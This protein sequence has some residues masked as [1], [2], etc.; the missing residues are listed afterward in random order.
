[1]AI[2]INFDLFVRNHPFH[3]KIYSLVGQPLKKQAKDGKWSPCAIQV[4]Y[5]LNNSGAPLPKSSSFITNEPPI[6]TRKVRLFPG[7]GDI[8]IID[9]YDMRAYLDGRYGEAEN[10]RGS[11]DKMIEAISGRQ[12][13]IRFGR[14]HVDVWEGDRFHQQ[15]SPSLPGIPVTD[16]GTWGAASTK[17]IGIFFWEVGSRERESLE[18]SRY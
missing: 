16:S 7:G 11:K 18:V 6:G 17:Q 2:P 12:G 13:I 9:V 14:A 4:S 15:A 1:M 5:A 10:Y 8:Y 3:D